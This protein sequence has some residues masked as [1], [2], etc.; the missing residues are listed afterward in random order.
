MTEA[1]FAPAYLRRHS[2]FDPD[3][4]TVRLREQARMPAQSCERPQQFSA[5]LCA[6]TKVAGSAV[7]VGTVDA[8]GLMV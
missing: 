3:P 7:R 6:V 8:Y 2:E 1:P 5:W 4:S